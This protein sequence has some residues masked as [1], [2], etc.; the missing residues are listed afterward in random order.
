MKKLRLRIAGMKM[1]Q[2]RLLEL[3]QSNIWLKSEEQLTMPQFYDI[4]QLGILD[5]G[6]LRFFIFPGELV[7]LAGELR[8]ATDKTVLIADIAMGFT[9]VS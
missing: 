6:N 3:N 7:L 4:L 5:I 9:I 2:L 1:G 8:N